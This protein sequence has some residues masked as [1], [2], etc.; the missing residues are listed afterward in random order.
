MGKRGLLLAAIPTAVFAAA[1]GPGPGGV[2]CPAI[3]QATAV[4]VTVAAPYAP[5]VAG[6]RLSACQ[7]GTCTEGDVELHPG[8]ATVDQGC[9]RSNVCSATAS[10]DGT[11]TGALMLKALTESPIVVTA[12]ATAAEGSAF[13]VRSVE[14]RPRA[15]YP[16]GEQCGRFLVASVLLDGDGLH[17]RTVN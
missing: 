7:D 10:P 5:Q 11:R 16:F 1:C 15:H 9:D 2:A 13:P 3:A 14:F 6:L 12:F 8:N 17:E 4:S